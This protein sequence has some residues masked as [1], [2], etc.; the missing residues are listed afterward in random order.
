MEGAEFTKEKLTQWMTENKSSIKNLGY[1]KV[2]SFFPL[3]NT[4]NRMNFT[5]KFISK[6]QVDSS[7]YNKIFK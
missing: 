6:F 4:I 7:Y 1:D 2:K 3:D 5:D